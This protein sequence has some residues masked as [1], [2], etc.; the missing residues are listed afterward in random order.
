MI[1]GVA[2]GKGGTGKTFVSVN[3]AAVATEPVQLLDADVEEPNCHLFVT[4]TVRRTER[5]TR[6]VPVVDATRCTGCGACSRICQFHAIP[7]L[8]EHPVV[9]RDLCHGC[10]GCRWVCPVGAITE[11]GVEIGTIEVSDIVAGTLVQGRLD[12]GQAQ[13]PPLIRAVR[14]E[15]RPGGLVIIDGP[16]GTA[17]PLA[18]ALRGCDHV[19]LVAE[20]TR[21]GLYDLSLAVETVRQLGVPQDVVVNRARGDVEPVRAFCRQKGLAILAELPERREAAVASAR[22]RLAVNE[23]PELRRAFEALLAAVRRRARAP[24]SRKELPLHAH[25]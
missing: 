10:G 23:I 19:L 8:A 20:P 3:L 21:F 18:A 17:C 14:R 13:S 25:L 2:S 15:V 11:T 6:P 4:P 5:V 7:L 24:R 12:V 1:L 9:F 22:G 16:P